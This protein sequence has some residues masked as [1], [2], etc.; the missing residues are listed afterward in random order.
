M[1][2]QPTGTLGSRG[3]SLSESWGR[4][5][6]RRGTGCEAEPRRETSGNK[7]RCLW[8]CRSNPQGVLKLSSQNLTLAL[9]LAQPRLFSHEVSYW[10]NR[11]SWLVVQVLLEASLATAL[12]IAETIRSKFP[13]IETPFAVCRVMCVWLQMQ[14]CFLAKGWQQRERA[15]PEVN[16]ALSCRLI[17]PLVWFLIW[18]W[19]DYCA[20]WFLL[21]F[22]RQS[23]HLVTLTIHTCM[24]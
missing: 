22:I 7:C 21:L 20:V 6:G 11:M 17:S 10:C 2:K 14:W 18:V 3:F 13:V 23:M 19:F 15:K 12:A 1:K 4:N 24:Q 5:H 16:F 8:T 9:S